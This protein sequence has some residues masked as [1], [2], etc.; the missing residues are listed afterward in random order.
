M[1]INGDGPRGNAEHLVANG[2]EVIGIDINEAYIRRCQ[3]R[4]E[5]PASVTASKPRSS[6][7][8]TT[9]EDYDV[10]YFSELHASP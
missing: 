6:R 5:R 7:C 9:K 3:R 2:I 10:V 1:G 8:T 4:M